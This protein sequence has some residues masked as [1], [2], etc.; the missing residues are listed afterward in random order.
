MTKNREDF[1]VFMVSLYAIAS[2]TDYLG[3]AVYGLSFVYFV[4]RCIEERL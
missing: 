2:L 3:Y 4:C 1:L